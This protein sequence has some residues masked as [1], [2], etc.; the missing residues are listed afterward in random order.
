MYRIGDT[1][2]FI[3][4]DISG[5]GTIKKIKERVILQN[6]YYISGSVTRYYPNGKR[7]VGIEQFWIKEQDLIRKI[8]DVN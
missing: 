1:V 7:R 8:E 6:L 5:A 3:L 4:K 2:N